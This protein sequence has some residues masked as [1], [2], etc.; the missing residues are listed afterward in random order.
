MTLPAT[1]PSALKP[2]A[3]VEVPPMRFSIPLNALPLS[4]PAL[5]PVMDQTLAMLEAIRVSVPSP[6]EKT[7]GFVTETTLPPIVAVL[8]CSVSLPAKPLMVIVP[9]PVNVPSDVA[10]FLVAVLLMSTVNE[11]VALLGMTVMM[12]LPAVPLKVKGAGGGAE[13]LETVSSS[14]TEVLPTSARLRCRRP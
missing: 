8:I 10:L 4:V 5:A 12:S 2:K 6:P 9:V 13:G 14:A 1:L 7:T 11:P 3:S